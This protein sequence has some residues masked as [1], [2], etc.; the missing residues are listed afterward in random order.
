MLTPTQELELRKYGKEKGY[1]QEKINSFIQAKKKE[2][3]TSVFEAP[4]SEPKKQGD[5]FLKSL[6]KEP[7]KTLLVKPAVRIAQAGIAGY[8]AIAKDDRALDFSTKDQT[9]KTPFGTYT[10]EGQKTGTAGLKQIGGD[11]LRSG[12]ELFGG[13]IANA[14]LKTAGKIIGKGA[15]TVIN[16]GSNLIG[17]TPKIIN[18]ATESLISTVDDTTKTVL[19]PTRLIPQ[20]ARQRLIQKG[21][22]FVE[23]QVIKKDKFDRY[24]KQ[25]QKAVSDPSQATPLDMAGKKA[26]E[27]LNILQQK[28]SK[29]GGLKSG[30]IDIIGSKKIGGLTQVRV[31]LQKTLNE[32]IG[33]SITDEGIKN[34]KGRISKISL[35]P[36]D[37]KLVRDVYKQLGQLKFSDSIRKADDVVD[38]I[39][40]LLYK[41]KQNYALP[42]N[43]QVEALLKQSVR[44]LN[45]LVKKAAGGTYRKS[46]SK[47]S[48]F[49]DLFDD[50]NKALG[51]EGSKGGSLMK[52]VFSP[53]DGGT[54]QLF[55]QIKKAT[56]IDLVEE[57]ALA[58][59]VMQIAGDPR[60]NN[61]LELLK[62]T[63]VPTPSSVLT[64][65]GKFLLNK[66]RDPIKE[67]ARIIEQG[68]LRP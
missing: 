63:G 36:A 1:S 59:H 13:R 57:A 12:A 45:Q 29:Q 33:A 17:K 40:D 37:N 51:K 38:A 2:T 20:E 67:S 56:G 22:D 52:R 42:V 64:G 43:S 32:K 48:N 5:S 60:G 61:L 66:V 15:S 53:T 8:G 58:K 49:K 24:L 3:I 65:A 26:Q 35:D 21:E 31:N 10:I 4:Q 16:K 9:I 28:L 44:E 41:R 54:K 34:A 25:A 6:V 50:L 7:I 39:Q 55:A 62:E 27:A 68:K 11:A 18:D 23:R 19:N 47:Y 30:V 14:G 46:N